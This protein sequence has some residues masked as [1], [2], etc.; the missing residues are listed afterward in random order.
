MTKYISLFLL[1]LLC[2][3]SLAAQ[4]TVGEWRYFPAFTTP[5]VGVVTGGDMVYY[6]AGGNLFS[7]DKEAEESRSYSLS[8][9]LNDTDIRKIYYNPYGKYLMVV[10]NSSNI[11]LIYDNGTRVVNFPD[12]AEADYRGDKTINDVDFAPGRIYIGTAFGLVEYDDVRH[13]VTQSAI[14]NKSVNHV[15]VFDDYLMVYIPFQFLSIKRGERFND[16]AKFAEVQGCGVNIDVMPLTRRSMLIRRT[17]TPSLYLNVYEYNE[18]MTAS[19]GRVHFAEITSSGPLVA[20]SDGTVYFVS[21][22]VLY[23]VDGENNT[24]SRV[25]SYPAEISSDMVAVGGNTSDVWA[26]GNNGIMRWNLS[27]D[28]PAVTMQRFLP[29]SVSV[30]SV[31][32]LVPDPLTGGIYAHNLGPTA[33]RLAG[34]GEGADSPQQTMIIN[35]DGTFEDVAAHDYVADYAWARNRQIALGVDRPMAPTAVAP[36]P[37]ERGVY[38]L[39]TGNE[40]VLRVSDGKVTGVYDENNSPW[41]TAFGCRIFAVTFDPAG[42]MWISYTPPEKSD[43]PSLWILPAGK[44]ALDPAD[45][46]PSDWIP[47]AVDDFT[48][49]KDVQ[50]LISPRSKTVFCFGQNSKLGLL[51]IQTRGTWDDLSDDATYVW[52]SF[53]DQDGKSFVPDRFCSM[54]EDS[55]GR[56]WLGT[57]KGIIEFS[58]PANAHDALMTVNRIK[59]PRNDGTNSADYLLDADRIYDIAEDHAGRKWIATEMSGLY[60]VSNTGAEILDH[61][62]TENSLLHTNTVHSVCPDR[63]TN[64]IWVG[65]SDGL[66]SYTSDAT[67]AKPDFDDV[68]VYPNPVRPEFTG[69]LTISGLMDGTLL[70]IADASGHVVAQL[71]S[72]GGMA[73]WNCENEAGRRVPSGVYFVMLSSGTGVDGG[74]TSG[75]VAK[76]VIVN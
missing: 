43:E 33:Y 72:E 25:S 65:T 49:G 59:V 11:D 21:D 42:N 35:S 12:I 3:F 61:F 58:N 31:A 41:L 18:E 53:T 47:V 2:S 57:D 15:M 70:K 29:E 71:R 67:P 75:A 27:G 22:D 55:R 9:L 48:P 13:E 32:F 8:G 56:I 5:V 20:G 46:T 66:F 50:I 44:V 39:A 69:M 26:L 52:T 51:V 45:I 16:L 34:N 38:Y 28:Q 7:Y 64:T 62:S 73:T 68:L 6:A 17:D 37:T 54:A 30:R 10:Y 23:A 4:N 14:Y 19:T 60:L 1:T 24:F 40:G 36:H 63:E 74:S 76:F